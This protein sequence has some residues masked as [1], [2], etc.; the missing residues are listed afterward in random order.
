MKY[1]KVGISD[2]FPSK[3]DLKL[4]FW[5]NPLVLDY[6]TDVVRQGESGAQRK[7]RA[8][9]CRQHSV[10]AQIVLRIGCAGFEGRTASPK[11][12]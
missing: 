8:N 10:S 6:G 5:P 11:G 9:N 2:M 7:L 12:R 3:A 4:A 1:A